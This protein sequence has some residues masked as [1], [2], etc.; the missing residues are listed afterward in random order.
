MKTKINA[1]E[2]CNETGCN[3]VIAS[4]SVDNVIERIISGEEIGTIF[5][6]GK[7]ERKK[8]SWIRHAHASGSIEVDEGAEKALSKHMSLLAVGIKDVAGRFDRGDVVNVACNGKVIAKGIP[9]Y[10]SDDIA[11]IKGLRSDRM[12]EVLGHKNYDNVIRSENIVLL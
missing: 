11:R 8:S 3:M 4:S 10:N 12:S 9:D 6:G 1:A 5:V 7:K 2:I